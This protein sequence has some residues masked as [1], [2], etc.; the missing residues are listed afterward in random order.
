MPLMLYGVSLSIPNVSWCG[1]PCTRHE[2]GDRRISQRLDS[3]VVPA[4]NST[5]SPVVRM[6]IPSANPAAR[7]A[8]PAPVATG[9]L[10]PPPSE[11]I[12]IRRV[13][14]WLPSGESLG[15]EFFPWIGT[16]GIPPSVEI[17]S[18]VFFVWSARI[19]A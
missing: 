7:N 16:L 15:R 11:E 1:T 17:T 14:I 4:I 6:G 18:M 12:V 19:T 8:S 5:R 9:C 10:H 3:P 13:G 2:P